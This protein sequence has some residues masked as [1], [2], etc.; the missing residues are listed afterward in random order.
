MPTK[1]A[2]R[3]RIKYV[4]KNTISQEPKT[5]KEIDILIIL[6]YTLDR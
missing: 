1:E 4:R 5:L 2:L 6:H 3:M